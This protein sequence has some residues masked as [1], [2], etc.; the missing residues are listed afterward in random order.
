MRVL[1][2]GPAKLGLV[3]LLLCHASPLLAQNLVI[4]GTI[5]TPQRV[6]P[7]GWVVIKDGRILSIL[8]RRPVAA[9]GPR[10]DTGGIVFPGFVNLHDHPMYNIFKRW[11]NQVKFKNRYEWRSLGEYN[12]LVGRPGGDLQ[13]PDPKDPNDQ[14]FCD[15]DEYVEVKSLIGG[16]MSITGISARR[17]ATPP[18]PACVYGLAR[19]L[20]WA[21]G[22]HGTAIGTERVENA[23]GIAP[24]DLGE[25]DAR[26]ILQELAD[27]KLDL[28][29]VHVAEGAP[30]DVESSVEFR[31]LKGV[32][33]LGPRT[34][35]IHGAA[36]GGDQL[37]EMARTGTALIWSPRSNFE[38][39]GF[40]AD[41]ATAVKEKVTIALAPDWSPTGSTSSL[42]ELRYARRVNHEKLSDLL[43]DQVLFEMATSIPAR[44]AHIDDKVG[45]LRDGLYADL[46]V[47]AGD[48]R[49]PYAAVATAAP[50]DVQLVVVG[51]MPVYGS[52]K[53]MTALGVKQETIEV[54]GT[55]MSLNASALTSGRFTEV[56]SRLGD[57]LRAYR[58]QLGPLAECEK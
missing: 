5:V 7:R 48:P 37:Q 29:L 34:A 33:L 36:L 24:R 56:V 8:D 19:N 42:A 58:L 18:V 47:L 38:L 4:S 41:I 54:C 50:G 49:R 11:N 44:I 14:R 35:I 26:R 28:L 16:T 55:K 45:S 39:Y 51:G 30:G 57:D 6:I 20:D 25:Q 31:A 3:L 21:S 22:F 46:F 52:A 17:Q 12:E 2:A 1:V 13:R 23:L 32:G 27:N 10:L 40:T 53:L 15:I 9:D 43:S